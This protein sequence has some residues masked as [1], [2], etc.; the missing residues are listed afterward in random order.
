MLAIPPLMTGQSK[1]GSA[2]RDGWKLFTLAAHFYERDA[3]TDMQGCRTLEEVREKNS[4]NAVHYW[5]FAHVVW[6][7]FA[8][9]LDTEARKGLELLSLCELRGQDD[10]PEHFAGLPRALNRLLRA[11][12]PGAAEFA[13]FADAP[14]L[15]KLGEVWGD[16][17]A[18]R[19]MLFDACNWHLKMLYPSDSYHAGIMLFPEWL[20][21]LD[22]YRQAHVG[23]SCLPDHPLMAYGKRI[24]AA[25]FS[26]PAH[27][28]VA[29]AETEYA[30]R[31]ADNPVDFEAVWRAFL[32]KGD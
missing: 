8:T 12:K 23:Q 27:P 14:P 16:D 28:L 13:A 31:Y 7:Q 11:D 5:S 29:E 32:A 30:R 20:F 24:L 2:L 10:L 15:Q 25:D 21:A 17:G 3:L 4:L 22:R 18:Y 1:D 19:Q 6:G 9:G 26:G